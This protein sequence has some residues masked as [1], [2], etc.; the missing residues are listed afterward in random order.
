MYVEK[1]SGTD[2]KTE[3]AGIQA[4]PIAEISPSDADNWTPTPRQVHEIS[5]K[6][7]KSQVEDI[8][9]ATSTNQP[10][11]KSDEV[12]MEET[13]EE[14]TLRINMVDKLVQA[15]NNLEN[16]VRNEENIKIP[17]ID[18]LLRIQ[19]ALD[20]HQVFHENNTI[21]ILEIINR[22]PDKSA[23]AWQERLN[24]EMIGSHQAKALVDSLSK[25]S[26]AKEQEKKQR[27]KDA[28]VM[29]KCAEI[30]QNAA[31]TY[32]F[33]SKTAVGLADLAGM[34][35]GGADFKEMMSIVVGLPSNIQQQAE[36][37]IREAEEKG[38]GVHDKIESVNIESLDKL[39]T[40]TILPKFDEKWEH[41]HYEPTKYL[42]VIFEYWLH[43]GMFPGK[44][45][46]IHQIAVKFKCSITVL[47]SY[48][49]GYVK[50]P[51]VQEPK[52]KQ[53]K[54]KRVISFEE[55]DE[56][57]ENIAPR[58]RLRLRKRKLRERLGVL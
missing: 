21:D 19:A 10:M 36:M 27:R 12:G 56:D 30:L 39:M 24:G 23:L 51:C 37:K 4:T 32:E 29:Q 46:N 44:K 2:R 1:Q 3:L 35:D 8:D 55:M 42:A 16:E 25:E 50:P 6:L 5:E 20:K 31:K 11:I 43:K 54:R 26:K 18:L 15:A 34:C 28:Y 52:L 7:Q 38:T 22:I 45:P 47:Q 57:T 40:A 13:F 58:R 48:L 9:V 49:R 41:S 14:L 53:C 17:A 33:A